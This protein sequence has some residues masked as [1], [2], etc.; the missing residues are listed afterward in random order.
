[1]LSK[2]LLIA[3]TVGVFF[4][5]LGV[6]YAV[7]QSSASVSPMMNQ[8][9]MQQMMDNPQTMNQWHQ[10][11]MQ[12][13]QAMNQWMNTMMDNP[14]SMTM[15]MN[16]MMNNQQ[17]IQ[18]WNQYMMNNPDMMNQWMGHMMDNPQMNQ[19]MMN[20]MMGNQQFMYGMMTNPQFQQNWMGP[21]MGNSTNWNH[22]M[23]SNWMNQGMMGNNMMGQ[24]IQK[25]DE[26]K[27]ETTLSS[28]VQ[29]VDGVQIVTINAK[30]FKFMPSTIS[31]NAGKTKFILV[32]DG[33]SEH[34]LVVYE[35]SK[36]DIVDKAE[37]AEDEATIEKNILFEIEEVHSR[38]SGETEVLILQEGT[39]VMGCHVPGH[40]AAGMKGTIEIKP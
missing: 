31:I 16:S 23:G 26:D 7:L 10:Q 20:T 9:Q 21:W 3:I 22:M 19:Q 6:G 28:Y 35:D 25:Q 33:L 29:M 1:M 2:A 39:Y 12:N 4:A 27:S 5:G 14:Q 24:Q 36:K 17:A 11:M 32:N 13:P 40:Y 8:Q 37:L 34:E 18:S 38:E 30:E 15:W